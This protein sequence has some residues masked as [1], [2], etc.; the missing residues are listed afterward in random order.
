VRT[1]VGKWHRW[2]KWIDRELARLVSWRAAR[3]GLDSDARIPAADR[4]FIAEV[5]AHALAMGVRR[6]LKTGSRD[7]SMVRLLEDIA[8]NIALLEA[9]AGASPPA[10][11]AVRRD[12]AA[13]KRLARPAE[14]F[15]DRAVAHA[16]RRSRA[17]PPIA[18][19]HAALERLLELHA[20]YGRW[21]PGS[22]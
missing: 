8:A 3:E 15:A 2:E 10:A 13:L 14:A 20:K 12:I 4:A 7:V 1:K 17:E 21:F 22:R 19:L 9:G 11:A 6:Q 5:Y 16:D 18:A